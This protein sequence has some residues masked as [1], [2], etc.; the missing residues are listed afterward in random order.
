[1]YVIE[2]SE[3]K[4]ENKSSLPFPDMLVPVYSHLVI[5]YIVHQFPYNFQRKICEAMEIEIVKYHLTLCMLPL[6]A[7]LKHCADWL[8][9]LLKANYRQPFFDFRSGVIVVS[10]IIRRK[11]FTFDLVDKSGYS[12]ISTSLEETSYHCRRL[13]FIFNF[14][15]GKC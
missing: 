8:V 13:Y 2:R 15:Y 1:M 12:A 11:N 9:P 14:C 4:V 3:M 10:L 5:S 7:K 6:A